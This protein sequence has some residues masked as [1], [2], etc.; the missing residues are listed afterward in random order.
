MAELELEAL[1]GHLFVVGGR[2]ISLP[3]PGAIAL[4][5]PRRSARGRDAD[6][7]FGLIA[8]SEEQRLSA[9]FYEKLI[10]EVY[11]HYFDTGGSVTSAL[12]EAIQS[13]NLLLREANA[14][15]PSQLAVGL[16]CS[17][18]RGQ[19]LYIAVVGP[20]R[21]FL[22]RRGG[23]IERLPED[24]DLG[25]YAAPLGADGEPDL[26]FYFREVKEGDFLILADTSL[27][28]LKDNALWHATESGDVHQTLNNLRSVTGDFSA[29]EIV[30]FVSPLAE[31]EAPAQPLQTPSTTAPSPT[32]TEAAR[33]GVSPRI[34]SRDPASLRQVTTAADES[35]PTRSSFGLER[36]SEMASSRAA[37][38]PLRR[39]GRNAAL[40]LARAA[41]WAKVSVERIFPEDEIDNP[42][43]QHLQLSATMQMGVAIAV[44]VIVAL[45][46]TAVYHWRGQA[47]KYAQLVREAQQEIELAGGTGA[48]QAE[49]RPHWETALF[50]LDEAAEIRAPSAELWNLRN[51]VLA[52]LDA[53][54]HVTR[55]T[56][57]ELREYELGAVLRGPVVQGPNLYLLDTTNDILY[58]EILDETGTQLVNRESQIV[59]RQGLEIQKQV[60]GGMIDLIW[61]DEGAVPQ[62]NVLAVLSR[63]GLLVTYSP[64]ADVAA[65]LLPAS[66]A[67]QDPRA[68]AVYN[69]DLYILDAGANEIWRYEAGT[70]SYDSTPQ[71]YF[72]DLI[73]KFGDA[74][75][76]VIDTNGNVYVLHAD[77]QISKYFF[78]RE[79][80]FTL[81]GLPQPVSRPTALFLNLSPF[82]RALY[83]T[84]P[85]GGRLYATAITG[86]FLF[87]YKDTDDTLFDAL[88]GVFNQDR[89][90]QI[91]V[92]AGNRLY[93][94]PRP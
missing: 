69:R 21:C 71:R 10:H 81:E 45:L 73:P 55:V 51:Q 53:Y 76:M 40:G 56:P 26:R 6:T 27:N 38:S 70:D 54:D 37:L 12:R 14:H 18:L 30:K 58:R 32:D 93:H 16:A 67:W 11:T 5:P 68:I 49:A 52:A 47:S 34:D 79:Q 7:F 77:G 46:T 75:D 88:S 31:V 57:V 9:S 78:G 15:D 29:A 36:S 25:S 4:P 62:R 61:M 60:V 33:A 72:T 8:L 83:I 1:V 41:H 17:V 64:S 28:R 91:Y 50:L 63:N 23:R 80:P 65:T 44:A 19:E 94:F 3:S 82:D 35:V 22:I 13:M 92:T 39:V 86:A 74:L 59:T 20:A 24:E 42:L 48:S 89:P 2:A 66:D 85:G 43:A 87:N 84:D 90:P